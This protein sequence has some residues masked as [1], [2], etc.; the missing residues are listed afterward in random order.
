MIETR[1]LLFKDPHPVQDPL[2]ARVDPD[3]QADLGSQADPDF[4]AVQVVPDFREA[5]AARDSQIQ[6][7]T[8]SP[9]S[10]SPL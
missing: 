3:S 9:R 10:L 5:P 4:R 7:V 1:K 6:P 8:A 2:A